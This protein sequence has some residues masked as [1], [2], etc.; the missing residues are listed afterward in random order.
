MSLNSNLPCYGRECRI[1]DIIIVQVTPGAFYEYIRQPCVHLSFYSGAKKVITG[2]GEWRGL[3]IGREHTHAMCADPRLAL[4]ERSCCGLV[5]TGT[6]RLNFKFDFHGQRVSAF[7]NEAD[8]AADG[9]QVCDPEAMS[10]D[11]IE[12]T[13]TIYNN[14]YPSRNTMFWTDASCSL[15]VKVREDGMVAIIHQ[16]AKNK[17]FDDE[18]VPYVDINNTIT[19]IT[20]PWEK[21]NMTFEE[22]FPSRHNTCGEGA[23]V[24]THDNACHCEVSLSE[25]AVF[26][27]LPSRGD[28]LSSL[29][30]GALP[31]ESFTDDAVTYSLFE[32]SADVEA[33]VASDQSGI[34]AIST[35]FKVKDEFG[36]IIYLKNVA[37]S[38]T[39]GGLYTM[40]NPPNFMQLA[41]PQVRDAENEV[42]AFLMHLIQLPSAPPF[43]AMNLLQLHGFS[44]PSPGQVE[45]VA[46]AFKTGTYSKGDFTFGDGKYGSLAA[47]SAAIALDP[48]SVLPVLDEDPVHGQIREPLLKVIAVMRSLNFQ[49][50]PSV[51][52]RHGLF[53]NMRFK[54]GQMVRVSG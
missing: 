48:E 16:P 12:N 33:Y 37:S 29:K 15:S 6:A 20:V 10:A 2:S 3:A 31:P 44:N 34:G 43:I 32:V 8:C 24:I 47:V 54:I 5:R 19:F 26:D 22:I 25:S 17:F 13:R 46:S 7:T 4:A 1:D 42:D 50:Q 38:I 39:L 23:C 51:K 9:G 35:I 21:D 11:L 30:I 52:L 49:R 45:R 41:A 40:R 18:T 14:P 28:I 53:D 36:R 27:S